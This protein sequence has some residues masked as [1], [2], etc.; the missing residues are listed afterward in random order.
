[1]PTAY[2]PSQPL[3]STSRLLKATAAAL[4]VAVVI[5]FT[6]IL[7]AEYGIDPTGIGTRLGLNV[8]TDPAEAAETASGVAASGETEP[9]FDAAPASA[10]GAAAVVQQAANYRRETMSLTLAPGT[11]AEIKAHMKAG[12]AFVFNWTADGAVAV[13][14]HGERVDAAKDEYTSY[15]IEREQSQASGSFTAPFDGSHGWYWLNRSDVPVTVQVD[16]SGFQQD[17][18]RP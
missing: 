16:V 9:A 13:D 3:P 17:L 14:M 6:T 15:W 18:Y 7:P 8:L 10:A 4:V 1:M 11:G 2:H 5:L 12:D